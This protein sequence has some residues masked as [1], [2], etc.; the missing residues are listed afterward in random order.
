[1]T[2][3]K[4]KPPAEKS[5]GDPAARTRDE[6]DAKAPESEAVP[7]A[8]AAKR[9][10]GT[11]RPAAAERRPDKPAEPEAPR[12][13]AAEP[14]ADALQPLAQGQAR[15]AIEALVAVMTDAAAPPAARISAATTLLTWG[16][17]RPQ[18]EGECAP[19]ARTEPVIRLAWKET[20]PE[21]KRKVRKRRRRKS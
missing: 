14:A 19:G 9:R 16:Y 2:A 6:A 20:A 3:R 11:K 10:S 8:A 4:P 21:P 1:M 13:V 17:G 5:V 15:R 12:P 7:P 18:G